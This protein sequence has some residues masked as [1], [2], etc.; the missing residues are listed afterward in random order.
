MKKITDILKLKKVWIPLASIIALIAL[1]TLA[2]GGSKAPALSTAKAVR[3]PI[4]E[5]VF[6]TGA[7]YPQDSFDLAF[8]KSG[9]VG[10]VGVAAGKHVSRGDLLASLVA[11]S[12]YANV[13]SAQAK[14]RS[15][16]ARLSDLQAGAQPADIAVSENDL[17]NAKLS[18]TNAYANIGTTL[19]DAGNKAD[20]AINRQT[21]PLFQNGQSSNPTLT[22]QTSDQQAELQIKQSRVDAGI[23]LANLESAAEGEATTTD[24]AAQKSLLLQSAGYLAT[25]QSFLNDAA[26]VISYQIG[27]P[28]ATAT[29][30]L[31]NINTARAN[32]TTA[33]GSVNSLEQSIATGEVAVGK[34][35]AELALKQAGSTPQ[36][37]AEQ[38]AVVDSAEADVL[39]AQAAYAQD[40][41]YAPISGTITAKN[42]EVGEIASPNATAISMQADGPFKLEANVPEADIA[43]VA[44]GDPAST[45]LDAFG[46]SVN[47]DASVVSIDPAQIIID[48]VATYK[49][50]L[51]FSKPDARVKSGMTANITIITD[52][53]QDALSIP[54][55]AVVLQDGKSIVHVVGADGKTLTDRTITTG[56]RGEDGSIEVL[57]GLKEGEVVT[58]Y[59]SS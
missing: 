22:F 3:G 8:Q 34:S 20:N 2:F 36:A 13:E 23:A 19:L 32:V 25:I 44:V 4:T 30:Y 29:A 10:A 16:Q 59:I 40:F 52:T 48:G 26:S 49:V 11:D 21:A 47:F 9:K 27:L 5:A 35:A 55:R 56:I 15:E 45:T 6:V 46:S 53:R 14:V 54:Q 39:S 17:A 50:T 28:A 12:E 42:I 51:D 57:S 24:P 31:D 43:N 41:L 1:A 58:T 37:I 18:L 38:Q 7:A 33:I